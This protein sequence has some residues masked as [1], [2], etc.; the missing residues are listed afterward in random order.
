MRFL[1]WEWQFWLNVPLAVAGWLAAVAVDNR[2]VI[3]AYI[4][5][6]FVVLPVLGLVVL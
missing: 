3:A 6:L 1:A 2:S 5:G 4:V